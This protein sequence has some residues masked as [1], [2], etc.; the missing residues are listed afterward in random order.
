MSAAS[1]YIV[2]DELIVADD[3]RM[4]LE[5]LGY[6]VAGIAQSGETAIM[7][8]QKTLPNLI[9]MDIHL[10]GTLDGI[11]TAEWIHTHLAIPVIYLTAHAETANLERAKLTEPYGYIIKPFEERELHSTIEIAL[12]KHR[13]EEKNRESERTIQALANAIPDAV[14]LLDSKQRIIALNESMA[15][16]LGQSPSTLIGSDIYLYIPRFLPARIRELLVETIHQCRIVQYEESKGERWFE[17]VISPIIEPGHAISRIVIQ[18]HDITDLKRI[19]QQI[20]E[21]GLT[22]IDQ[23]M[24]EF[25]IL[26]DQ[27]RNPLQAISGYLELDCQQYKSRIQNQIRVIDEIITRLDNGWVE[28]EKVRSFLYRHY[29]HGPPDGS[30]AGTD[31]PREA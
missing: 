22:Q 6:T 23:N 25:Q 21:K 28:S 4:T 8:I 18:Y 1:V 11:A 29:Y 12:Y 16:R 2:E 19:E 5:H 9:L 31:T 10:A 15:Q 7:E 3:I 26:N 27:I 20:R 14:L 13:M 24:E 30:D 17:V